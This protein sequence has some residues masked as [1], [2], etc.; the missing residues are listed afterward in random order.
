MLITPDLDAPLAIV[1]REYPRNDEID[2]ANERIYER[3]ISDE[4]RRS[5]GLDEVNGLYN[6]CTVKNTP[7]AI[8][9]RNIR[10]ITELIN[11]DK[12]VYRDYRDIVGCEEDTDDKIQQNIADLV[13]EKVI[14]PEKKR[15]I[16]RSF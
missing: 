2:N 3:A 7:H 10:E 11:N 8:T 9:D 6:L 4:E 12:F 15:I 14:N 16:G 13:A 1:E 5:Y